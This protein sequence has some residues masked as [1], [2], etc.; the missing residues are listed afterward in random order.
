MDRPKLFGQGGE[1][2]E[3]IVH[4]F[5][6]FSLPRE[7][8]TENDVFFLLF[9]LQIWIFFISL[10]LYLRNKCSIAIGI[11]HICNKRANTHLLRVEIGVDSLFWCVGLWWTSM[12]NRDD[13]R[14]F[15]MICAWSYYGLTFI[16]YN[17]K[18]HSTLL[19]IALSIVALL[20]VGFNFYLIHQLDE[21]DQY[22]DKIM[23]ES[24]INRGWEINT[25][26]TL[27]HHDTKEW[28]RHR[29]W[30]D[31][32]FHGVFHLWLFKYLSMQK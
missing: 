32:C 6:F 28:Y 19:F 8:N 27:T 7:R 9:P 10:R 15:M 23:K 2:T 31:G 30:L 1:K 29:Q 26:T 21:R 22:C 20:S 24:V 18:R 13:L 5:S 4:V 12:A 11:H 14:L 17:M 16:G 3:I 25:D